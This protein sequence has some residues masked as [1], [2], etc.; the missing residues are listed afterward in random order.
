MRSPSLAHG[1]M[2]EVSL[3]SPGVMTE[4]S[5]LAQGVM[6]EFSVFSPGGHGCGLHL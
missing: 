5:S 3:F 4:V 6:D 2:D 1:V